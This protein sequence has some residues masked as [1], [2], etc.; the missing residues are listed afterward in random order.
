VKS[1]PFNSPKILH[2][3]TIGDVYLNLKE[4][5]SLKH[6]ECELRIPYR[7]AGKEFL[8]SPDVF[9]IHD[10][11]AHLM[12]VQ[13]KALS[14]KEWAK[15]WQRWNE[16]FGSGA[17]LDAPWQRFKQGGGILPHVVV[18]SKQGIDVVGHGFAVPG[19]EIQKWSHGILTT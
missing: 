8:F 1:V 5:G 7:Y 18:V 12:E 19:R 10:K 2:W 6:F 17:Y 13:L 4:T 15:K 16:Y 14:R 3:L 9:Y 11:R